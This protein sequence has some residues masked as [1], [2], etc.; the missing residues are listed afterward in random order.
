MKLTYETALEFLEL[1]IE[2]LKFTKVVLERPDYA[3]GQVRSLLFI[4]ETIFFETQKNT[5]QSKNKIE[6]IV[7]DRLTSDEYTVFKKKL[8]LAEKSFITNDNHNYY[9]ERMYRGYI[10]LATVAIGQLLCSEGLLQNT[11]DIYYMYIDEIK[12]VLKDRTFDKTVINDRKEQ[13]MK[14]KKLL[15]PEM[16][17]Q[18]LPEYDMSNNIHSDCS[19]SSKVEAVKGVSGLKKRVRGK[20]YVGMP[21]VLEEDSILV[22]PHSHCGD[23]LPLLSKVKGLI[24]NWGS[25]YDHPGIIAREMNIP[26]IY[27]TNN[28]MDILKTGDEIELDGYTGVVT[29]L[30][31]LD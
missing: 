12:M 28:A 5:L 26:A 25:P 9:M 13:Y 8:I 11:D 30:K 14:Q 21:E 19:D 18:L 15:A 3:I 27:K 16:I 1:S 29:V 10:R 20:V 22:L 4:D 31:R 2:Y 17:G 7:K 23:I 24:F 6:M